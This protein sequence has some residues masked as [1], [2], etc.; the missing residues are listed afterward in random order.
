MLIAD[1][2]CGKEDFAA[3]FRQ[4]L[5]QILPNQPLQPMP[6]DHPALN[7]QFGGFDLQQVETRT[8][9]R[10][11]RDCKFNVAKDAANRVC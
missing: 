8:P 4:E 1:A 9:S 2:I 10:D 7:I 3:A 5:T 11:A 6:Q